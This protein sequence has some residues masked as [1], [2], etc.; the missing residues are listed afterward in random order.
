M[1]TATVAASGRSRRSKLLQIASRLV[2]VRQPIMRR[3]DIAAATCTSAMRAAKIHT[4]AHPVTSGPGTTRG[5][6]APTART[7]GFG[8]PTAARGR[9]RCRPAAEGQIQ[10]EA[11]DQHVAERGQDDARALHVPIHRGAGVHRRAPTLL[12]DCRWYGRLLQTPRVPRK[13][14]CPAQRGSNACRSRLPSDALWGWTRLGCAS[15][16]HRLWGRNCGQV[17]Q[18]IRRSRAR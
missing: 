12:R 2:H 1:A 17:R 4:I 8:Q 5:V 14:S 11:G 10:Q 7:T 16:L 3:M 15:V 13:P 9:P 6:M 18:S